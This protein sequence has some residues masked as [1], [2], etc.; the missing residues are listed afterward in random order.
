M[1]RIISIVKILVKLFVISVIKKRKNIKKFINAKTNFVKKN[2]ILIIL[3]LN[4]FI[5]I[6]IEYF[7]YIN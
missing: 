2:E 5:D 1:T 3:H 7:Y 4:L 6:I